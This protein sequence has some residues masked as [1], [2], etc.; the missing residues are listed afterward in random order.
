MSINFVVDLQKELLKTKI[1]QKYFS[2][3]IDKKTLK[4]LAIN[5]NMKQLKTPSF[6][7]F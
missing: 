1:F 4:R 7:I 2:V 6:N 3:N 5:I